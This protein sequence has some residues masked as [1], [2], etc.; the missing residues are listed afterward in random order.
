MLLVSVT[1]KAMRALSPV[2]AEDARAFITYDPDKVMQEGK[3]KSRNTTRATLEM[4]KPWEWNQ[5]YD[6]TS[7][8]SAHDKL[9]DDFTY[10]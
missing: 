4:I 3:E 6:L 7:C 8:L 5:L 1:M 2:L 10:N 9:L